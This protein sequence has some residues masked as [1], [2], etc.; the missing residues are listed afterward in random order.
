MCETKEDIIRRFAY[1][2]YLKRKR[3]NIP[4]NEKEDWEIAVDDFNHYEMLHNGCCIT[5]EDVW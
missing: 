3:L 4:L 5:K 2:N 1:Q